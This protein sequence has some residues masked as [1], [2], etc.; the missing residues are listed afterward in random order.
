VKDSQLRIK[1]KFVISAPGSFGLYIVLSKTY[2]SKT[3]MK[4]FT[5]N[6]KTVGDLG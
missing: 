2:L 4:K 6:L 1:I 5:K 3:F